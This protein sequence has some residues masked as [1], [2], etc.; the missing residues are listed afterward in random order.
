MEY[1]DYSSEDRIRFL[2]CLKKTKGRI[3]P[4]TTMAC[5]DYDIVTHPDLGWL[6]VHSRNLMGV[7]PFDDDLP[8]DPTFQAVVACFE[9][10][11]R[12]LWGLE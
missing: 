12:E 2:E 1:S 7:E 11:C 8:E 5:V 3:K 4:A 6:W 9:A 10:V